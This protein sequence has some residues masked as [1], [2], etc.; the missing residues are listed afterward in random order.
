MPKRKLKRN[1]GESMI[2]VLLL[3]V[4]LVC[5]S[6]VKMAAYADEQAFHMDAE[7]IPSRNGA[8]NILLTVENTG[9]DWYGTARLLVDSGRGVPTPTDCAY[10][11]ALILPRG[12][13]QQLVVGVPKEII[14]P[15]NGDIQIILLDEASNV[16][17]KK[18]FP[19]FLGGSANA[20]AMGILS[21][22]DS[23]LTYLD[24]EG[25]KISFYDDNYSVRLVQLNK[26][27][28]SD[29]LETLTF[30]VIDRYNTSILTKDEISDIRAWNE[31]GG[32]LIVGTGDYAEDTLRGLDYL[33]LKCEAVYSPGESTQ[34]GMDWTVDL[35]SL[36]LAKL[37][38]L[39][40][41]YYER[42]ISHAFVKRIGDG[43]V[44][45][46]PYSLSKLDESNFPYHYSQEKFVSV[47]L[48]EVSK[49]GYGYREPNGYYSR[50]YS[51]YDKDGSTGSRGIKLGGMLQKFGN[52][53]GKLHFGALIFIILVYLIIIGPVLHLLLRRMKKGELYGIVVMGAAFACV[54]LIFFAGRGLTV[55]KPRVYSVTVYDLSRKNYCE[56][57]LHC[58]DAAHSE[59]SLRLAKGYEYAGPQAH[60]PYDNDTYFYHIK[61]DGDRLSLGIAPST[62]FEDGYFCA[63]RRTNEEE[64]S[65]N[66]DGIGL[67]NAGG[68]VANH[69]N[70]DFVY[71]AV[72]VNNCVEVYKSL[73]AGEIVELCD[74]ESVFTSVLSGSGYSHKA[75][76]YVEPENIDAIYALGAG[77]FIVE[78]QLASDETAVIGLVEDWEKAVEDDCSEAAYGCFYKILEK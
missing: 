74:C 42:R 44:G 3:A 11:T 53:D 23:S 31:E 69:T 64:T 72:I 68:L 26:E 60:G 40:K 39:K 66:I 22:D 1:R 43:G 52:D 38:D 2:F 20:L 59:W 8:F 30:L 50:P 62:C 17:A 51:W 49:A 32:V 41:N 47:L 55:K 18:T 65:Y 14:Y 10:D 76:K 34:Y 15:T 4:C 77:I 6:A 48:Y 61:K 24:M 12:S 71:F 63:G 46:L 28:L 19:A 37:E 21:D 13:T 16:T 7:L 58:Y 5:L 33:E 75:D 9:E 27:N 67:R 35:S 56:T 25:E 45:V 73:P 57:Y 70:R 29:A 36:S 78:D 54:W